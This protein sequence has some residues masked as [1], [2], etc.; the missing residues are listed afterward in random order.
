MTSCLLG[1]LR[2]SVVN[3]VVSILS[4]RVEKEV[5]NRSVSVFESI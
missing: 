3:A 5:K 1:E 2:Y 4:Y